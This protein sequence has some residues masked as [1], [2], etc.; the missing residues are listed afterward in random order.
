MTLYNK[1]FESEFILVML[2][3]PY[4]DLNMPFSLSLLPQ[5]PTLSDTGQ[6]RRDKILDFSKDFS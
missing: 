4:S 5:W 1:E 2:C 3:M 6:L